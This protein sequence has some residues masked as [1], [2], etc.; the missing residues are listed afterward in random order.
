VYIIYTMSA[1]SSSLVSSR[2]QIG[3]VI[4]KKL[5]S[6]INM[7]N[8]NSSGTIVQ[9]D[10][11]TGVWILT[12]QVNFQS[13]IGA[14]YSA[15]YADFS[16]YNDDLNDPIQ[17]Q[18]L[19]APLQDEIIQEAQSSYCSLSVSIVCASTTTVSLRYG[20]TVDLSVA[21]SF[22][23]LLGGGGTTQNELLAACIG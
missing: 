15:G 19:F 10:L 14:D 13:G 12:A 20:V 23:T 5:G 1:Q 7:P 11:P 16:I 6:D 18:T 8:G 21:G 2:G 4:S 3:Q 9:I 22:A 17:Q